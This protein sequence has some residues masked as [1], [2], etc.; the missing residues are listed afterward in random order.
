M[1]NYIL[2][3]RVTETENGGKKV[4]KYVTSLLVPANTKEEA[5]QIVLDGY[6]NTTEITYQIDFM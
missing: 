5:Q 6:T 1:T 4:T 2:R 3:Y